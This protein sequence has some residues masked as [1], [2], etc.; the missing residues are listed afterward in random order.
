LHALDLFAVKAGAPPRPH[1]SIKSAFENVP[2]V[3]IALAD[4]VERI[5][6]ERSPVP[7]Q[8]NTRSLGTLT[9]IAKGTFWGIFAPAA[10][11]LQASVG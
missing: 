9:D 1:P 6:R 5:G 7:H 4:Q 2:A 3:R 8:E 10:L 11:G